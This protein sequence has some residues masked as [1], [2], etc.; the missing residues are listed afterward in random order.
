MK[1]RRSIQWYN[2]LLVAFCLS[3]CQ[4]KRP[5][6]IL[7]DAQMED[8]LHDYHIAKVMGEEVPYSENYKRVLYIESVFKKHG[9]TQAIFDSSMVWYSRNPDVISKLYE[10]V[11]IRLKAEKQDIDRLIALRDNK[12]KESLPGDS[13]DV[14]YGDRIYRLTGMPL[15]NKLTFI[16]PSDLNFQDRD[17]LRWNVCFRFYG[18]TMDSLYAPSMAMQICYENDSIISNVLHVYHPGEETISLYADT[19]GKIKEVRGFIFYPAQPGTSILADHISLMRYH[20]KDSLNVS[21]PDT[22]QSDREKNS[23]DDVQKG[24]TVEQQEQLL[25]TEQAETDDNKNRRN[26]PRPTSPLEREPL[27]KADWK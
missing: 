6:G 18:E 11:N 1:G 16:I 21:S 23:A 24:Q 27:R 8:V 13:I 20:A 12:P 7:P 19:L 9:I 26:R 22:L 4:V 2:V 5:A 25:P 14:W 3:A 10:K 17:T 15:N